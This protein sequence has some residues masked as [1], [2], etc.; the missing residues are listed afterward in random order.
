MSELI[1]V[2]IIE[3]DLLRNI[4]E[5]FN[6]KYEEMAKKFLTNKK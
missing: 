4:S 3:N 2:N 1:D 6:I 5:K